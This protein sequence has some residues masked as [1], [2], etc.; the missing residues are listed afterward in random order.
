MLQWENGKYALIDGIFG[1]VVKR[2]NNLLVMKTITG[3]TF[4]VVGD[5]DGNYA[6]GYTIEEARADLIF[7][8]CNRSKEDYKDMT[9]DTVLSYR[10]AIVCYRVITGA[11]SLGVRLFV[12]KVLH[13]KPKDEY[14]I[15]EVVEVTIGQY[16]HEMFKE[17][18]N[19]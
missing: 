6:H 12:E 17:F 13:G 19:K 10:D 5:G 18:W 15:R 16:R 1:E 3:S 7:K 11:C 14:S 8:V 9:L 2:K 4:C